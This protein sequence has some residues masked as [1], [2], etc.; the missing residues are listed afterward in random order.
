MILHG[1]EKRPS[2]PLPSSIVVAG[3]IIGNGLK[4]FPTGD[5]ACLPQAGAPCIWAFLSTV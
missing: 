4:S 2:A 3:Y 5:F 1:A